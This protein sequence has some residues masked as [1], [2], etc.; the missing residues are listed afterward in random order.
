MGTKLKR[1]S[2]E[3]KEIL[4][5][6]CDPEVLNIVVDY[7]YGIKIPDLV[8]ILMKYLRN[9]YFLIL[10]ENSILD[11][12]ARE[13]ML[14]TGLFDKLEMSSNITNLADITYIISSIEDNFDEIFCGNEASTVF[15]AIDL[16]ELLKQNDNESKVEQ[17]CELLFAIRRSHAFRRKATQVQ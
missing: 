13:K 14:E 2:G 4:I 5:E 1:W 11:I 15:S 3:K 9:I 12:K 7:M 6:D 16:D 17:G 8:Y 10:H